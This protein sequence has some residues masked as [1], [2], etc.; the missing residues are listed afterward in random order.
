MESLW[1]PIPTLTIPGEDWSGGEF[2]RVPGSGS[3][4]DEEGMEFVEGGEISPQTEERKKDFHDGEEDWELLLI[5]L[6]SPNWKRS[7]ANAI[8]YSLA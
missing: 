1:L 3:I 4:F 6:Q 2:Y 5:D 7:P 8:E